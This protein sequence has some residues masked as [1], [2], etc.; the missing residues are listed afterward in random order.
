MAR[1]LLFL[2]LL[3]PTLATAA[4]AGTPSSNPVAVRRFAL[5]VGV[6]DGGA[7]RAKLRYAVTDANAFGQVL[8]ELGG[9]QR[10]DRMMLLE[11]DRKALESALARFKAMVAA[12]KTPGGRTEALIY[13]S[14]HSDEEGLLLHQDRFGYRELRQALE[15]LP[16]DV[17]IA[18]LDSC[19]SGTLARSKGG[20]RRPA[21]LVDTSTAVRGHAILTSSS[22][23]EVSQESDRIGGSFF[24]HNLVSGLR[25][26]ADATGDGRVT[27][28]EAYQFAFHE[29]LARTERTRAG[30]QHPAYDIEL[31]GT[32][33][34]VMTDLRT[35]SAVLVMDENVE[36]R[37]FIRDEPGRLVVELNKL[38]GR[39]TEL[40]LQP[41]RY[42][43]TRESRGAS[44][45]AVLTVG[46][47]G[48]T[49]LAHTAFVAMQGELTAMRGGGAP[50]A[51]A[52][53]LMVDPLA[54]ARGNFRFVNLG[55]APK[56]QTND[57]WGGGQQMDNALSISLGLATMGRLDGFAMALGANWGSGETHGVQT[58]LGGNVARD[59]MEGAQLAV[60]G[61]W[62]SGRAEGLQAAVGLNMASQGGFLGQL[63]VG[64]NVSRASMRGVQ[65]A[66]GSSW[67]NGDMDGYQAA[68]GMSW[69]AGTMRGVQMAVGVSRVNTLQGAQLSLINVG[70]D[71]T[72]AQVG[73]INVAG[74][75]NGLQLGII[76]VANN[77]ESGVPVGLL[78]IVRNGQFHVEAYGND[79]NYANVALKV[80]SRYLY[81]TLV[82]GMGAVPDH[83]G[84]SHW[85]TGVGLGGHVPLTERLYFDVDVVSNTI[86]EWGGALADN[87]MLHQGRLMVGYAFAPRF[88]IFAG[89]TFNLLHATDGEPVTALSRFSKSSDRDVLMWAGVQAGLRL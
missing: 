22:E 89:P 3:L 28:H 52:Q 9:V 69:V 45:R 70:G 82:V 59:I 14:G 84:P 60:G 61:N 66:V 21:F 24:T 1:S 67:V 44:S 6:N 5:L 27:L 38:A 18:I 76:N 75:M 56:L 58:A 72:G 46:D 43:V 63:A 65:M 8:E 32:G 87:R 2:S 4:P 47:A 51:G 39:S 36:G 80:G 35:T 37:L 57:L 13:Y 86:H 17:R 20:V 54:P 42:T 33:E 85:T 71:V 30:A 7:G 34:L 15:Q 26:A 88:A 50:V 74:K 78:N 73:L 64:A 48:R 16:A 41:G 10:Q 31:A 81:T 79:F 23:D 19:A 12:G 53:G 55:L 77:L 40:G 25:G 68:V 62:V 29:T 83:R 11:G 49:V